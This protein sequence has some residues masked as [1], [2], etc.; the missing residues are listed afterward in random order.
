[1]ELRRAETAQDIAAVRQLWTEYWKILGLPLNFQGFAE[2]LARLP[3]EFALPGGMLLLATENSEPAG[4]IAVRRLRPQACEAKRLY[5][6]ERFRGRGLG[7]K[8]LQAAIDNS[9]QLG[10]IEMYGDTLP[11]M[12][13]AAT[14]YEKVGFT[15]IDAYSENPT[16]GAIYLKLVL[17]NGA[18]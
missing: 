18:A 2:Q 15:Q 8:L 6:P 7:R 10:Y 5:I 4:T 16:P 12:T 11:T 3:G 14:L 13:Q 17:Q 9:R 1:M